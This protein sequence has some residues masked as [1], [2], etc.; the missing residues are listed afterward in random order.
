MRANYEN[1][2]MRAL[3]AAWFAALAPALLAQTAPVRD[4]LAVPRQRIETADYV[5]S[6][7]LVWVQ[8][9]D[10][11]FS[12]PVTIKAHWFPGVLRV[13]V[14]AGSS[15]RPDGRVATHALFE[16][17]PNGQSAIWVAHPGDKTPTLLPPEKWSDGL[18]SPGVSYED[19]LE[20]QYF[21]PGQ[22][23]EGKARFGAR[24]C[25]VVK[26]KPGPGDKSHY[27][28]VKTWLDESIEFPVYVEKTVRE[29]GAVKE[30]TY[31]GLRHDQGMWSAH[32]IE[33]TVHGQAGSTLL[34]FDR[35]SAKAKLGIADFDPAQLT[36]F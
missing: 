8:A 36:R 18:V 6:G 16:M 15:K 34:I 24:D 30:F 3:R 5:V 27:A 2:G 19:L 25:E 7:H 26:S 23:A 1:W 28:Q 12:Y 4:L 31:F 17:R 33:V 29:T 20:Q 35:G 10:A 9:R 32:Q 11:R 13:L 21:W 14:E 22:T